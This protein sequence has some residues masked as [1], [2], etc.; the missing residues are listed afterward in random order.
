VLFEELGNV[1]VN[2]HPLASCVCGDA[3]MELRADPDIEAPLERL[4]GF[5]TLIFTRF[6]VVVHSFAE[7]L[8][9][10]VDVSSL[11]TH[12]CPNELDSAKKNIILIIEMD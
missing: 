7:G 1:S 9:E 11:V 6:Q 5:S 8:A 4:F 10:G 12:K 3:L 2:R